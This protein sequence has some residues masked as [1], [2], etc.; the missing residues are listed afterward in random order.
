MKRLVYV[1]INSTGVFHRGFNGSS[2]LMFSE[3]YDQIFYYSDRSSME[4]L[5]EDFGGELPKNVFYKPIK[6]YKD[7]SKF[8]KIGKQ[9]QQIF[10]SIRIIIQTHKNDIVYFNYAPILA[11]PFINLLCKIYKRKILLTF[12]NELSTLY[13]KTTFHYNKISTFILRKFQKENV[14][15]AETLY[16]CVP[17]EFIEINLRK[18][19]LSNNVQGKF[20]SFE[21]TWLFKNEINHHNVKIGTRLKIGFIGTIRKEKWLDSIINFRKKLSMDFDMEVIGRVFCDPQLLLK[22]NIEFVKGADKN[23][24]PQDILDRHICLV[25]FIVFL[26]P[27]TSYKYIFSGALFDAIDAEKYIFALEND[28]F[29]SIINKNPG[30]GMLFPDVNTLLKYLNGADHSLISNTD[31]RK[32]KIKFSPITEAKVFKNKLA[33]IN[34]Y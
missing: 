31:F 15:W 17:G 33:K 27:S 28:C 8:N 5:R 23:F 34:F 14:K 2:L 29:S 16:F 12:H 18:D 21:H 13:T 7:N 9:I 11:I 25:D 24:I 1:D 32:V 10:L 6:L 22:N 3:I 30:I 20:L 4:V 26:Y 19:I